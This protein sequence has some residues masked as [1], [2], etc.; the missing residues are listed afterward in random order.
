M[1]DTDRSPKDTSAYGRA[2]AIIVIGGFVAYGV[3]QFIVDCAAVRGAR[4]RQAAREQ[5][6]RAK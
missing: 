4:A 1:P 3:L 6:D 5:A 2:F